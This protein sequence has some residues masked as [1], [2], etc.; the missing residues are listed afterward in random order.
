MAP[1]SS[2]GPQIDRRLLRAVGGLTSLTR[3]E[4]TGQKASAS[5]ARSCDRQAALLQ[6][7]AVRTPRAPSTDA[8]ETQR[9][10]SKT[11]AT[12][13]PKAAA[14]TA[15]R[16]SEGS[17]ASRARGARPRQ[18]VARRQE[19]SRRASTSPTAPDD[20]KLISGVGPQDRGHAAR[21]RHLHLCA[22]RRAG[23][24]PSANGSMAT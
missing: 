14:K 21:P 19:P 2:P 8:I 10:R 1:T 7:A 15:A 13:R 24:R 16:L 6:R 3:S 17:T 22:G 5:A 4:P 18:A 23:R 11:P 9:R 20:L 12:A